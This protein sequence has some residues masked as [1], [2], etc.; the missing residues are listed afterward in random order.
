M[1]PRHVRSGQCFYGTLEQ[2]VEQYGGKLQFTVSAPLTFFSGARLE[3]HRRA[4]S[5]DGSVL[6]VERQSLPTVCEVYV[7]QG[8]VRPQSVR[9]IAGLSQSN[10]A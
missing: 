2:C 9:P 3:T 5:H 10:C 8:S 4:Q 1:K 6:I 7:G